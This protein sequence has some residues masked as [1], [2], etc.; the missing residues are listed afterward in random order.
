MELPNDVR[1]VQS[2]FG[3]FGDNVNVSARYVHDLHQTYHS[4][5]NHFECI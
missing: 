2:S 5:I 1:H 4:L 3:L